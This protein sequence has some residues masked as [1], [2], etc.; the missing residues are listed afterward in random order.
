MAGRKDDRRV[1]F[2]KKL[3]R[4]SLID[5]IYE[6]PVRKIT[7]KELCEAADINRGTFYTHFSDPYGLL[8]HTEETAAGEIGAYIRD[9][10]AAD[11]EADILQHAVEL[12]T[13]IRK[14][15]HF[16]RA[17]LSENGS[18]DFY[19]VLFEASFEDFAARRRA[20]NDEATLRLLYTYILIGGVGM[21]MRW[22]GEENELPPERMADILLR[23][24]KNRC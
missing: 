9:I 22:L 18:I 12:F 24:I 21:T 15:E 6:K 3:L 4:E 2:T 16:W 5:L 10:A 20:D 17:L 23:V 11:Q 7:V 19:K 8:R 13:Y 1:Q 14:N